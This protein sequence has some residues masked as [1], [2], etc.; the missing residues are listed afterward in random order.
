MIHYLKHMAIFARVVDEGSFRAAAR[1]LNLAPSRV[2]QTVSD[3]EDHLGITLLYRTTRK[4]SLTNEGRMFYPRVVDMLRNA[5]MGLNELNALSVE[6]V[7]ALNV[8]LPAYMSSSHISTFLAD[9]IREYPRVSLSVSYTDHLVGLVESGFDLNIRIGWLDDSSMVARKLGEFERVLV[10]GAKYAASRP[11]PTKPEDL[12]DWEWISYKQRNE[13]IEFSSA[14]KK[15]VMSFNH[16]RLQVDSIDALFHFVRQNV[17]IS[18]LPVHLAKS[19]LVSG[20][21][22]QLL[23]DWTLSPVGCY[24]VWPDKSRR[25]NLTLLLAR[26]LAEKEQA[27]AVAS[28][29]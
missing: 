6:P 24:A 3:L 15:S 12:S 1:D 8:S 10:A 17:G 9:F 19:G 11:K 21:L 18:V 28:K 26:F 20:E 16:S 29:C 4:I 23:P 27:Y 13:N 25:A 5:E 2:S 14:D 22:V 7:G